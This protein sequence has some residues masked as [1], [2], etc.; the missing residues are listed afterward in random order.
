[1]R[2]Q[3][4]LNFSRNSN[5]FQHKM[6][7]HASIFLLCIILGIFLPMM[8]RCCVVSPQARGFDRT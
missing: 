7:R 8:R 5:A 3:P 4:G 1:V 6:R 2:R